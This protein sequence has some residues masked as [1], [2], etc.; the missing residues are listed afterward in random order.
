MTEPDTW[1]R[2]VPKTRYATS[3]FR[4]GLDLQ[5]QVRGSGASPVRVGIIA[6]PTAECQ[7]RGRCRSMS[8]QQVDWP[9]R[10]TQE[11]RRA[12]CRSPSPTKVVLAEKPSVARVLRTAGDRG[13]ARLRLLGMAG[14]LPVRALARVRRPC[15]RGRPDPATLA[16]P[17]DTLAQGSAILHLTD[18]GE[19]TEIPV[20]VG[21]PGCRPAG[22]KSGS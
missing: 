3:R 7:G 22:V 18:Q 2:V 20:P 9:S 12:S 1:I 4:I 11:G 10:P 13:Q 19:L 6:R 17:R 14:G 8:V 5:R 16:T 21:D 15:D